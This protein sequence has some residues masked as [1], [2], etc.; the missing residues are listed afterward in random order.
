LQNPGQAPQLLGYLATTR[1][2]GVP[3]RFTGS[4]SVTSVTQSLESRLKM[5]D[6]YCQQRYSYLFTQ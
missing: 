4:D 5:Q 1:Q 6:Y 3:D 2:S